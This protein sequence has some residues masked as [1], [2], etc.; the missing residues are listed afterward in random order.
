MGESFRPS[1]QIETLN[2]KKLTTR[3]GLAKGR[4]EYAEIIDDGPAARI[5]NS[6]LPPRRPVPTSYCRISIASST[7]D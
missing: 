7:H 5:R 3:H 2:R 1:S 4:F 6:F